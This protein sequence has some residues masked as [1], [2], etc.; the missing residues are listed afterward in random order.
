[1]IELTIIIVSFNARP[2]LERCLDSL[3]ARPPSTPHEIVV[4]DNASIDASAAAVRRRANVRLLTLETNIGFAAANNL[5][6]R[7]TTGALIL[8]LNS[9]TVATGPA[10]DRL[11]E[12]LRSRPEAAAAGPRLVDATGHAEVSFGSMVGPF[13]ELAQKLRI[14]AY[15]RGVP[16]WASRVERRTRAQGTRDWVS[17]ACLLVRRADAEAAGLFDERYFMYLEDVDFCEALRAQGR[18]I[19]FVPDV[20]IVHR[21]GASRRAAPEATRAA[22]RRSQLAFYE[23]HHPRWV[24]W[25][26]RYLRLRGGRRGSRA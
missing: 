15:E 4:V 12:H 20:E 10:I 22:Y 9:D 1:M 11:V 7:Q 21:R 18:R 24:P 23:K 25:L 5:A 13:A 26:R 6:I 3:S 2:D 19:L 17:G 14:W 16:L 8:L